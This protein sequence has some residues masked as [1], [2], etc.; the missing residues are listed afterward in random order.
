MAFILLFFLLP[1]TLT[2][3]MVNLTAWPV[4]IAYLPV[5]LLANFVVSSFA[6]FMAIT[7]EKMKIV[8]DYYDSY[9][10]DGDDTPPKDYQ[11]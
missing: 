6:C 11:A 10:E 5:A 9:D 3:L 2:A 1:I 8:A 7:M 4:F